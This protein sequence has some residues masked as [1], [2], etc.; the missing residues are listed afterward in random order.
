MLYLIFMIDSMEYFSHLDKNKDNWFSV[1]F[2]NSID[3]MLKYFCNIFLLIQFLI[4]TLTSSL[5]NKLHLICNDLFFILWYHLLHI[6]FC[7][8]IS[9]SISFLLLRVLGI[10]FFDFF[11]QLKN[12]LLLLFQSMKT[13]P[14]KKVFLYFFNC[15]VS[16]ILQPIPVQIISFLSFSAIR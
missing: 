11:I 14:T 13:K 12:L 8:F 16:L 5:H 1:L 2:T 10:T 9:Q 6:L 7:I 3:F 15:S 4:S